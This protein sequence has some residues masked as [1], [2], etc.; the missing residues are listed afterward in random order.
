MS[1]L[2]DAEALLKLV[3]MDSDVSPEAVLAVAVRSRKERDQ[4]SPADGRTLYDLLQKIEAELTAQQRETQ[5]QLLNVKSG[6]RALRGY[7]HLKTHKRNQKIYTE[8]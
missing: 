8:V 5:S 1:A 2:D 7:G 6:K 4:L 3:L